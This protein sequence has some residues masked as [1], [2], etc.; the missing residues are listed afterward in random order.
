MKLGEKLIV[1]GTDRLAQV[2]AVIEKPPVFLTVITATGPHAHLTLRGAHVPARP[3][4]DVI[5]Y[6]R[7]ARTDFTAW[8]IP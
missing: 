4:R 1:P 8:E 7:N 2:A 5:A 6:R 3:P